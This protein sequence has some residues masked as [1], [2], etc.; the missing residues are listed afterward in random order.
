MSTELI[1]LLPASKRKILRREYFIRVGTLALLLL[2]LT[3]VLSGVFMVP[4]YIFLNQ[5]VSSENFELQRLSKS[6]TTEEQQEQ[7]E[8]V[9]LQTEA[10]QLTKDGSAPTASALIQT[11]LAVP[12]SGI[13]IQ[14]FIYTPTTATQKG[15]MAI[16]GTAS[17]RETLRNY[18]ESLSSLP[19]VTNADLPISDYASESNIDF[20]ITLTG[21]ITQS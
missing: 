1:N 2:A 11:L 15:T 19:F 14:G 6:Q 18:D 17:T 4:T 12:H 16:T 10:A 7:Q 20:T 3:V 5:Q 21:S 13:A 9:A 8:S